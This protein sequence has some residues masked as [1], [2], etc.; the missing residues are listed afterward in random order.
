MTEY[1]LNKEQKLEQSYIYL[2]NTI[3]NL[4]NNNNSKFIC[5][6]SSMENRMDK[7]LIAKNICNQIR[8]NGK[9]VLLLNVDTH[10][11]KCDISNDMDINGMSSKKLKKVF[12]DNRD[13]YDIVL[14]NVPSVRLFANTIEC[15]KLCDGTIIVERYLY[16][17]YKDFED[18]IL[19]LKENNIKIY[20]LITYR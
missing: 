19:R 4:N 15:A 11:E 5:V 10:Y 3:L 6:T 1:K 12:D 9:N 16:T 18:T 17:K 14:I 7:Y 20:G 2:A 13:K 8:K